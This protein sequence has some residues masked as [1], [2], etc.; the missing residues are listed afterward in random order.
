MNTF[1]LVPGPTSSIKGRHVV[2]VVAAVGLAGALLVGTSTSTSAMPGRDDHPTTVTARADR[3]HHRL[4]YYVAHGC[5]ITPHT[6]HD[7][8]AGPMPVCY[9]YV[10]R[11]ASD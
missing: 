9:T 7:A 5:F 8:L 6:W 10:P 11:S 2:Q 1:D 4:G 3:N